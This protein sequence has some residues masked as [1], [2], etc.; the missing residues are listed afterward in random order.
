MTLATKKKKKN[1]NKICLTFRSLLLLQ[2]KL[3]TSIV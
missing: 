3:K 1:Q 2:D